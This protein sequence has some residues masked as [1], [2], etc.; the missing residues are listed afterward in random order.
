MS[1]IIGFEWNAV[2]RVTGTPAAFPSGVALA[3]YARV[4]TV[5]G[6]LLT[7]LTTGNGRIVRNSDTEVTVTI[8]AEDTETLSEGLVLID[9]ARTDLTP[10]Q[11]FGAII[12]VP[13]RR[14][15]ITIGDL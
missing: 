6:R 3:G 15:P 1:I 13:V 9:L 7:T 2:I 5:T 10:P 14:A 8:P 11:H 4:G 12:R